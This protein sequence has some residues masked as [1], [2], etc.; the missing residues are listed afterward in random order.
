MTANQT[1]DPTDLNKVVKMI[2]NEEASPFFIKD[3]T[4][5]NKGH[6]CRQQ[7]ACDNADP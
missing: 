6:V 5:L 2:K 4:C 1:M 3:H 7:H